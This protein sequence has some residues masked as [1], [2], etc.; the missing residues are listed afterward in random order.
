LQWF[1]VLRP[2]QLLE[3]PGIEKVFAAI[4]P[5]AGWAREQI[6]AIA[7]VPCPVIDQLT[8]AAYEGTDALPALSFVLRLRHPMPLAELRKAWHEPKQDS[9]NGHAYYQG[10]QW[11]YF[12][13]P[14][15]NDQLLVI[16]DASRM[17]Q[18]IEADGAVPPLAP[19][20][21][22]LLAYTDN[23]RLL[24]FGFFPPDLSDD[25]GPLA[26]LPAGLR[27]RCAWLMTDSAKVALLSAHL[28]NQ[29]F[30]ELRLRGNTEDPKTFAN[31][32][33]GRFAKIAAD[34]SSLA[35]SGLAAG[36]N[37]ASSPQFVLAQML[38][39]VLDYSRVGIEDEQVVVRWYLPGVAAPHLAAAAMTLTPT[40]SETSGGGANSAGSMADKLARTIDLSFP[41][42]TLESSLG[43]LSRE[44][45]VPIE[46]LGGDLQLE[47][48]TK[49]HSFGLD[50][51]QRSAGE[52][53]RKIL[54]QAN[55][56][57]KLVY[58]IKSK[59]PGDR[60]MLFVTTRAAA[61]KRGD[62][63]PPELDQQSK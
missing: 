37:P 45:G 54:W 60:E 50:E 59:Q 24:T 11:A 22:W 39:T 16:A 44:I 57:G 8:V 34:V 58:V 31:Q 18:I 43:M 42:E 56:D 32:L 14:A 15:E 17:K 4:G 21:E 12:L 51:R 30:A 10:P 28:D 1:L 49:N 26:A 48:I 53:L 13:P 9:C 7:G 20:L 63:I 6:E 23:Q 46:I 36:S 27:A 47:G 35:D 33:R 38:R 25:N 52:I 3:Q 41:R 5:A 61:K 55:P 2:A 62:T 40:S 29:L 19:R